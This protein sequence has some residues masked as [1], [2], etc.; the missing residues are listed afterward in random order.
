MYKYII[1]LHNILYQRRKDKFRD[2][3][4]FYIRLSVVYNEG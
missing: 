2:L 1:E 4:D 3:D